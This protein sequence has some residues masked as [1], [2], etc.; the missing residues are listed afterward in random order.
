MANTGL[1]VASS[2]AQS[3]TGPSW[4]SDTNALV[5]DTSEALIIDSS[6]FS[7]T[8]KNLD[9]TFDFSSDVPDGA[10]IDGIEVVSKVRHTNGAADIFDSTLRLVLSGT[11]SGDDKKLAAEWPLTLTTRTVGGAA[12]TWG[13]SGLTKADISA[14]VVRI[15]AVETA[16]TYNAARIAVLMVNIYYTE[17]GGSESADGDAT[18]APA[19]ASG[20][21]SRTVMVS[22]TVSVPAS[23]SQGSVERTVLVVG[24]AVLP[25]ADGQGEFPEELIFEE[26]GMSNSVIALKNRL[27]EDPYV[28]GRI[29][30]YTFAE[31]SRLAGIFAEKKPFN[32]LNP[33]VEISSDGGDN[34]GGTRGS[35]AYVDVLEL[36][37]C[38]NLNTSPKY[39]RDFGDKLWKIIERYIIEDDGGKFWFSCMRPEIYQRNNELICSLGIHANYMES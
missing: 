27:R 13:L 11:P 9:F 38:F 2:V 34:E 21:V 6:F 24:A 20:S 26:T 22:S 16:G 30:P 37:I 25:S 39:A 14:L 29:Q 17:S 12:D 28:V 10:A 8:S 33:S 31:G 19:E 36:R 4:A 5:D 1:K 15:A 7:T 35:R 32:A 3:G 18:S 23:E